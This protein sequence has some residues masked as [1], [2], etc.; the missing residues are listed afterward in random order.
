MLD[1]LCV[2]GSGKKQ[3]NCCGRCI[4]VKDYMK[5]EDGSVTESEVYWIS[6]KSFY[7][8]MSE[9]DQDLFDSGMR[10]VYIGNRNESMR[11]F[12]YLSKKYPEH[13]QLL[14][15]LGC[16]YLDAGR[17]KEAYAIFEK[18][19]DE[20]PNFMHSKRMLADMYLIQKKPEKVAQLFDNKFYFKLWYPQQKVIQFPEAL[21]FNRAIGDYYLYMFEIDNALRYF[22]VIK[23]IDPDGYP[24]EVIREAK[25]AKKLNNQLD[26]QIKFHDMLSDRREM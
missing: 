11:I 14:H 22:D 6:L 16:E 17:K 5:N 19:H 24:R 8:D 15:N 9:G 25:I 23:K 7:L 18:I 10:N 4:E 12:E 21:S 20:H 26:W 1:R 13:H 3:K 2:C